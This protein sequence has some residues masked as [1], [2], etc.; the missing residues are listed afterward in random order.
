MARKLTHEEFLN[1]IEK[2]HLNI[3][4]L[5]TYEAYMKPIKVRC[6]MCGR[7]W[8]PR[9]GNLMRGHQ[10]RKCEKPKRRTHEEYVKE[11]AKN[12]PN[13]E[14]LGTFQRVTNPMDFKCK[15][16]GY[17]WTALAYGV[18]QGTGC[19][20]CE[21][22]VKKTHEDFVEELLKV[23]PNIEVTGRY[24]NNFTPIEFRCK[25][26]GNIWSDPPK[27]LLFS[28]KTC[29]ACHC[30]DGLVD[31]RNPSRLVLGRI[32]QYNK[33][34]EEFV[35]EVRKNNPNLIVLG[36]YG[37]SDGRVTI[38]CST[39]GHEWSPKGGYLLQ[40]CECPECS[41]VYLS[42]SKF[43]QSVF[44]ALEQIYGKGN[45]LNRDRKILNG[46]ELD[47]VIP[48][49]NT[50]V[51][52][53][54]WIWH[55]NHL[56]RDRE[57]FYLC[58]KKGINLLTVYDGVPDEINPDIPNCM[59]YNY[60]AERWSKIFE[61]TKDILT[62]LGIDG[63]GKINWET[64]RE[65][66]NLR[67]SL[68]TKENNFLEKLHENLPYVELVGRYVS[69]TEK[70]RVKCTRC[71]KE[72]ESYPTNLFHRESCDCVKREKKY[73]DFIDSLH[74]NHPELM[75]LIDDFKNLSTKVKVRCT[76]CGNEW[77]ASPHAVIRYKECPE[78]RKIARKTK[79]RS[80][81][82]RDSCR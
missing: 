7:V 37:G 54:S 9:A 8:Y 24:Q 78:C 14:V 67:I 66:V 53:G 73:R 34:H 42:T 22:M 20:R 79:T 32:G 45:V 76:V 41:R 49:L 72:W 82:N 17:E 21:G 70:V 13:V 35:E 5:G 65:D 75:V 51:E 44:S 40:K 6:T 38:K 3:E 63:Q 15:V 4:V 81:G 47:I 25:K 46:K 52:V 30:R 64:V 71:G 69:T 19:P 11:V 56:D 80:T 60:E 57:K 31:D 28:H 16:C 48:P 27:I 18:M 10:C 23:N 62:T 12:S 59:V 68:D 77:F 1:R 50:A 33:T 74:E 61:I 36:K 43:E 29:P 55:K 26:C 58:K 2:F 39:C